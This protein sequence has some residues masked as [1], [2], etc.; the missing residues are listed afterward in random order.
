MRVTS[1]PGREN[2]LRRSPDVKKD[3]ETVDDD[4]EI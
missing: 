3:T 1:S 2:S 4:E